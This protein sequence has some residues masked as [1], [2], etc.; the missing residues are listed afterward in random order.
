VILTEG[1]IVRDGN[2]ITSWNP[3]TA[4]DV[5]LMLLEMLTTKQNADI[6]KNRMGFTK[7]LY[8]ES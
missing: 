5:A 7:G 1:P 3:S 8:E 6:I 2:I 4:V